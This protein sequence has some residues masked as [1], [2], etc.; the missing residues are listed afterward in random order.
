MRRN[1]ILTIGTYE[2]KH[3][4]K[5]TRITGPIIMYTIMKFKRTYFL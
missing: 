4:N 2:T 3:N 1:N 5:Y